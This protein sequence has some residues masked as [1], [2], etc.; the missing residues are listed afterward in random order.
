MQYL[1]FLGLFIS[2]VLLSACGSNTQTIIEGDGNTIEHVVDVSDFAQIEACCDMSIIIMQGDTSAVTLTTDS[3]LVDF[4]D[5]SVENNTLSLSQNT[6]SELAPTNGYLFTITTPNLNILT[7]SGSNYVTADSLQADDFRIVSSG[8]A[9][10]LISA[11]T[12]DNLTVEATGAGLV[13]I[14]GGSV[15]T[16]DVTLAGTVNYDTGAM[17]SDVTLIEAAST[18]YTAVYATERLSGRLTSS[19]NIT[20]LGTPELNIDVTGTGELRAFDS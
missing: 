19:G 2:L 11:L 7:I 17:V 14:N 6:E 20:Y 1:K 15:T 8:S 13:Q 18:G 12:A 3:N 10:I 9:R 4:F 5:V 16:Q